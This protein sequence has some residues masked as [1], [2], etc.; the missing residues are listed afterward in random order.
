VRWAARGDFERLVLAFERKCIE[1]GPGRAESR[2]ISSG[3]ASRLSVHRDPQHQEAG[4]AL[5]TRNLNS[6]LRV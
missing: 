3:A 6:R 2:K 4:R 1:S 5:G